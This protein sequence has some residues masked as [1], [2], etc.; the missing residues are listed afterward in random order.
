MANY[1]T[2]SSND[3]PNIFTALSVQHSTP[4]RGLWKKPMKFVA[5][6][7]NGTSN[8]NQDQS[9]VFPPRNTSGENIVA[10]DKRAHYS[11]IARQATLP[12]A[13]T[14]PSIDRTRM[15]CKYLEKHGYN[16][17]A[18]QGLGANR[19]GILSPVLADGQHD[20]V[21]LGFDKRNLPKKQAVRH[22]APVNTKPQKLGAGKMRKLA[23]L[24]KKRDAR[25]REEFYGNGDVEKY[26]GPL[27]F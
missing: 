22:T 9:L 21:G 4:S 20:K 26:L 5:T 19:Q 12:Q 3:D 1:D 23:E 24:E 25:L 11:S 8:T 18:G 10:K 17:D 27:A 6:D 7:Y 14:P 15:G 16:A 2:P 13:S